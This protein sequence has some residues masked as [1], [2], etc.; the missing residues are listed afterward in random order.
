M[1]I[2]NFYEMKTLSLTSIYYI[3][4]IISLSLSLLFHLPNLLVGNKIWQ[5]IKIL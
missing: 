5:Q 2:L 3:S 1:L 4:Q